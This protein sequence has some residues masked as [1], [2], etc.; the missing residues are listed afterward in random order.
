MSALA[1]A[2]ALPTAAAF[3]SLRR[4]VKSQAARRPGVYEFLDATGGTIYVGKAKD[5]RTR[6]L[7]YFTAPWP[8]SKSARLVRCASQIRWRC[9]P[10]EF[11]AL[12]EEQRLISRLKP[13]Y[14]VRGNLRRG[15]LSFVTLGGGPAPRLRVSEQTRD[16]GAFYYGP[17]AARGRTLEAARTL[18]DLLGLRDCTDR[19]P[20]RFQDQP[21][22]FDA[23]LPALCLRHDLGTCLAPCAARCSASGYGD[24]ARRAATFLD[25]RSAHP[26][27]VPLDA[28]VDASAKGAFERAA[29][30][31]EKF[32]SLEWLFGALS[33]LR[34]A[35]EGLSFVY[36]VKDRA[37]GADDRV[38]SVRHGI[39][40]AEAPWPR[41]PLERQ[42]FAAQIARHAAPEEPAPAARTAPEMDQLLLVMSWFRRHP[43]EYE[44]T[45]P[46]RRWIEEGSAR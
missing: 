23:P 44:H 21:S 2:E 36:A 11:A 4:M 12:L 13:A 30:W 32:E 26:L 22:L 31:L 20:M 19:T 34:A 38:Y 40:R 33:R 25:G 16:R 46:W 17:F 35:I 3:D 42:A 6:L 24:A 27:D 9:L 8:E 45:S 28:M 39:V 29:H 10:S 43:D 14:N 15:R 18:G 1:L 41:T 7:S 5:L 37:G